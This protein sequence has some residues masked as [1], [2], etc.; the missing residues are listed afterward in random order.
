MARI[1]GVS[2]RA[3]PFVR[4]AYAVTRR[5]LGR[6][7]EPVAVGAHHPRLLVGMGAFEEALVRSHRVPSRLKA[8]AALQAAAAIGCPF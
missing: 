7:V 5:K 1:E 4:I 6:M 8:L 2:E 3:N